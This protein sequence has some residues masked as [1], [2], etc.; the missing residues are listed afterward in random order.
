MTFVFFLEYTG[1]VYPLYFDEIFLIG[2]DLCG[3]NM[4]QVTKVSV[5]LQL[6]DPLTAKA[7]KKSHYV[8]K[9][10][11]CN[12]TLSAAQNQSNITAHMETQHREVFR[13][14][15][16]EAVR[17]SKVCAKDMEIRRLEFIQNLTEIV[18]KNGRPLAHLYDSGMRKL[19]RRELKFLDNSGFGTGLTAGDHKC[20]PAVLEHID[21]LAGKIANAISVEVK[22]RLVSLMVDI[23]SRNNRDILG[24]S[25]QYMINGKTVTRSLGMINMAES[26]TAVNIKEKIL[27]CLKR[28]G[29]QPNQVV[30][31][32][33]DNASNMLA[34]IKVFNREL[35]ASNNIT[36]HE[37]HNINEDIEMPQVLYIADGEINEVVEEY[38]TINKLTAVEVEEEMR[39]AEA[40]AIMEDEP[41]YLNLLKD[42]QNEFVLYTLIASGI[43]CAAHTLQL[44][45][46]GA[47]KMVKIQVLLKVCRT[48]CKLLRKTSYKNR[49]RDRKIEIKKL[50]GLDC[51]VR[52]N[53]TYVMVRIRF[54]SKYLAV[55]SRLLHLS[56]RT[57]II[58]V[59]AGFE[60]SGVRLKFSCQ[61]VIILFFISV[62][63][64]SGQRYHH[65]L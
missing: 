8:C 31:I 20:P 41:Y 55:R 28:F 14:R 62:L 10:D 13:K 27:A 30:S 51:A 58:I 39:N 33:S 32:T 59:T 53:S 57:Y 48:A 43:K 25:V 60:F 54:F 6:C 18:T 47:L 3:I 1:H 63:F 2:I 44:A 9:V 50:P 26:H 37:E 12:S 64:S 19:N 65:P 4:P 23:G 16:A 15:L 5:A 34:M 49:L 29:M 61:V 7:G 52:W 46:K 56:C 17:I 22:G 38:H 24:V 45:V 21:Y 42:L 35:S 40:N 36:S 11:G